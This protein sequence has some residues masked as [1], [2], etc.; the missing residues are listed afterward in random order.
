MSR[1]TILLAAAATLIAAVALLPSEASAATVTFRK[2]DEITIPASGA[3]STYPSTIGVR[4]MRGPVTDIQVSL[5]GV[6][7]TRPRD[8]DVMLVGPDG[9]SSTFMS[10]A[11]GDGDVSNRYWTFHSTGDSVG[12]PQDACPGADYLPT[13]FGFPDS[14]PGS[15]ASGGDRFTDWHRKVLTGQWKLYVVDDEAGESGRI[16]NGWSLTITTGP[17]DAYVPGSGASG[18]AD[19]YPLT[20]PV[21]APAG[22]VVTDVDVDLGFVEHDAPRDL[23]ILLAGP[24]GQTA[25]LMSDAC[26]GTPVHEL[27]SF[28][29][30]SSFGLPSDGV[31]CRND[32]TPTDYDPGDTFPAPAPPGPHGTKLSAFDYTDPTGEWRLYAVDDDAAGGDGYFWSRF[33][34]K[35]ATRPRAAVAFDEGSV[36]VNEGTQRALTVTR[37]AQGDMGR[38]TVTVSTAP[39]SASSGPDFAPI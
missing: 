21:A 17:V 19:P 18:P 12:M 5:N 16:A 39:G 35:I 29:D 9:T 31:F 15:G 30:E 36:Q 6:Y 20:V 13:N 23:D 2:S 26:G 10:D 14:F 34:L 8:L 22:E 38:G 32:V 3:A 11:C 1:K 33:K 27:L 25:V 24:G 37:G 4:N 28:N 7:H